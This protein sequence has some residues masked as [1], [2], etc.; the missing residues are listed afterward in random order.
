MATTTVRLGTRFEYPV[1]GC[2]WQCPA[3]MSDY[4]DPS[5][6]VS[7]SGWA[8]L[9]GASPAEVRQEVSRQRARGGRTSSN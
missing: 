8:G 9:L 6:E 1:E 5:S 7:V 2:F 4:L 3:T